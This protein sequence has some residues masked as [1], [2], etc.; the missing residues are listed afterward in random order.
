MASIFVVLSSGVMIFYVT[1][2]KLIKWGGARLKAS[3]T[4]M[5][6]IIDPFANYAEVKVLKLEFLP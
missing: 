4:V 2:K 1:Y 5:K 6:S 3:S